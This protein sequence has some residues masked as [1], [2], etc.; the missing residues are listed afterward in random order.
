MRNILTL[1]L[2]GMVLIS[3]LVIAVDISAPQNKM[4]QESFTTA[5]ILLE[6]GKYEKAVGIYEQLIDQG[7][8]DSSLFFNLGS[9]YYQQ[10]D[11]GRAM[12]NYKRAYQLDPR[13]ADIKEAVKIME[14]STTGNPGLPTAAGPIFDIANLT[15]SWLTINESA[16]SLLALWSISLILLMI[17][18][19]LDHGRSRRIIAVLTVFAIL[20]FALFGVSLGSRM[21]VEKSQP[22]AVVIASEV[23]LNWEP[24]TESSTD[25]YLK[26]GARINLLDAQGDW[27]K[28]S[29]AGNTIQG[30][31]PASTVESVSLTTTRI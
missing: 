18:R 29:T 22:E 25:L 31:V 27:I 3:S 9:A 28:L 1:L 15:R 21:F 19:M 6:A 11:S 10:G 23:V 5:N 26:N 16:I 20:I 8:V 12:L 2:T 17:Y 7:A 30:W 4:D 13:D 14:E 24:K